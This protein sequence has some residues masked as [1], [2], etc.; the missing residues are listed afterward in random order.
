MHFYIIDF[1]YL[2]LFINIV[3][4]SKGYV[5]GDKSYKLFTIYLLG[6][7]V[8]QIISKVLVEINLT[9]LFLS[10]FYFVGQF[11]ALS[12]FF[13]SLFPSRSQ[14]KIA[15]Y[16]LYLGL[17]VLAIQYA[18]QPDVWFR[19]NLFEIFVTAFLTIVLAAMHLFNMLTTD[20][21]Y[22]YCTIGILFYLFSSTVLFI[23]GNLTVFLS[24]EYQLLPWTL[25]AC[26]VVIYHLFILFEWKVSFYNKKNNSL[27]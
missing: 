27:S 16:L 21:K 4:Y 1:G 12:L 3:V 5:H 17:A 13:K 23:V 7:A 15:N 10:H 14:Q 22:Y 2:L 26:M 6:T 19:F 25:N 9:N 18:I 11:V 8:I 24:K 20:K